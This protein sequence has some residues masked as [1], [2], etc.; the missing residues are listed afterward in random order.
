[1]N[2]KFSIFFFEQKYEIKSKLYH[3]MSKLMQ[4]I[5][6][7]ERRTES[8]TDSGYRSLSRRRLGYE[9]INFRA[10]DTGLPIVSLK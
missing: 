1:M 10:V 3:S 2:F 6:R 7:L 8:S 4:A 9:A 5:L